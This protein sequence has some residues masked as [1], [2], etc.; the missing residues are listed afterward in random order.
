MLSLAYVAA[1]DH[2]V[3]VRVDCRV[4][5]T[6]RSLEVYRV[7]EVSLLASAGAE[8]L[9]VFG[10]RARKGIPR[11]VFAVALEVLVRRLIG[12]DQEQMIAE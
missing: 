1:H 12:R 5:I 3:T 6:V 2:D 7:P 4:S 11:V 8:L 9:E 10:Q